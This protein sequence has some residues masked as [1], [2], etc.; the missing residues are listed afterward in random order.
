MLNTKEMIDNDR[1]MKTGRN[2]PC[3]CGSGK[4]YK[5]CCMDKFPYLGKDINPSK[6]NTD[7]MLYHITP[8][9]SWDIIKKEGLRGGNFNKQVEEVFNIKG[10]IFFTDSN[11]EKVWNGIMVSMSNVFDINRK[12]K[13]NGFEGFKERLTSR[14]NK[15]FVVVGI[16][17]EF[18]SLSGLEIEKDACDS[19][20]CNLNNNQ[21]VVKVGNCYIHPKHL[22]KVY[23]GISDLKTYEETDR[24]LFLKE[25][26]KKEYTK[27]MNGILK[28]FKPL[29][30]FSILRLYRIEIFGGLDIVRYKDRHKKTSFN[31]EVVKVLHERFNQ[32]MFS[33]LLKGSVN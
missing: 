28:F 25:H 18:F 22:I 20:M 11:D 6:L 19:E 1:K 10:N 27:N 9:E 31:D 23:E 29:K 24:W 21:K 16:P 33:T 13:G 26:I 7:D 2:R 30:V 5:M 3:V 14:H 32:H 12:G 4:K 15:S 17:K 8:K